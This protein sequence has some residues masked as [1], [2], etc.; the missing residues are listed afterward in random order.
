MLNFKVT[1]E[2]ITPVHIGS[3]EEY[4]PTEYFIDND[5][6]KLYVV[7]ENK[8]LNEVE[9]DRKLEEFAKLASSYTQQNSALLGFIR[10]YGKKSYRYYDDIEF[11]AYNYLTGRQS[12]FRAG[13]SR[14]I[15]NRY[16]DK[17]YIPGSTFK[18]ALRSSFIDRI[19][20]ALLKKDNIE[21]DTEESRKKLFSEIGF[22]CKD[23]RGRSLLDIFLSNKYPNMGGAQDDIFK[24]V[25]VSDLAPKT[26]VNAK[27]YRVF[28]I[29][30][31]K[32][33][34]RSIKA[35]PDILECV[36]AKNIFE[37]TLTIKKE[38]IKQI[39]TI[40]EKLGIVIFKGNQLNSNIIAQ[41][42]RILY[43][44]HYLW[45]DGFFDYNNKTL[46]NLDSVNAIKFNY[47]K[48]QDFVLRKISG[49]NFYVKLGKHGGAV[50]KTIKGCRE[51]KVRG[52]NRP[53]IE[54]TTIWLA[55]GYPM[56]WVKGKIEKIG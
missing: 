13:I 17:V 38:F 35:I 36:T 43:A 23:E 30:K 41:Q 26:D 8:L 50:S 42:L 21:V 11:L 33:G 18:G 25:K 34:A 19:I 20:R 55:G 29:G 4:Y 48:V 37:G 44:N 52:R 46:K 9:K 15:R 53:Q 24:Y 27:I 6:K 56:G 14:F 45:E 12:A 3:G 49:E 40:Q 28:S 16:D 1:L 47:V 5:D 31:P 39:E 2:T 51:I 10:R 22:H 7:D 32:N 54:Q